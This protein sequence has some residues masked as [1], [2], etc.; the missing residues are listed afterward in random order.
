MTGNN[1]NK[2]FTLLEMLVAATIFSIAI[3]SLSS[4]FVMGT[5]GQRNVFATQNLV[6]NTRYALE[7]MSRQIRMAQRDD[8]GSCTGTPRTTFA[9]APSFLTF[10]DSKGNCVIYR[11][12]GGK[13]EQDPGDGSN[14]ALTSDDIQVL[15]L[16]F[17]VQ[18][19]TAKD[20][21]QPRVTV[22]IE[23]DPV[24]LGGLGAGAFPGIQL[25]TTVSTRNL[26]V[27]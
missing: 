8:N 27:P 13:I 3:G 2:G 9:A 11:K 15:R 4:L 1:T 24:G 22:F 23:A 14:L 17:E 6:S 20:G 25:Q 26:D 19:E 5:R 18:G 21:L 16:D 10:L 12:A 7:Y